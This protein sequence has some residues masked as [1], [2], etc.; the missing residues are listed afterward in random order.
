MSEAEQVKSHFDSIAEH[1]KEEIPA[2]IRQH[3]NDKWWALVSPFIRPGAK[4]I[5]LGC[6]DGTNVAFLREKGVDVVGVDFSPQLI[7][8]GK[9]LYPEMRDL[10][11]VGDILDVRHPDES[12]DVGIITGVLHHIYSKDDQ[13]KGVREGLRVLR[14]GGVLIIR[15]CN[16]INPLFRLYWNYVFPLTARIDRFGG[17]N[18]IPA[19][20][21]RRDFGDRIERIDFFT[22]IPASTPGVLLPTL[23]RLEHILEGS[24]ARS[25]AAHYVAILR[26]A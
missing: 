23:A 19:R 17:E 15:E 2:H 22:F 10:L 26:K 11:S 14:P 20:Q 18:W 24:P 4:A 13:K 9:E 1:Y 16:L 3:L 5:D 8:R 21:L 25:L 6:G 7:Q 12:F